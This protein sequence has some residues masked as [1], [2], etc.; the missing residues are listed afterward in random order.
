MRISRLRISNYRGI[1]ELDT[2]VG[3]GGLLVK[4]GNGLGKT[5][6]LNAVRAA[7]EARGIG[8]E[9]I[10]IGHDRAE[11]LVDMDHFAVKRVITRDRSTVKITDEDGAEVRSP[12]KWLN[13]LVGDGLDPI[14]FFEAKPKDRK[15]IL[16]QA[17]PLRID[18]DTLAKHLP[19]DFGYRA[20]CADRHAL[21]VLDEVRKNAYDQ[22]TLVNAELK[23]VDAE[24]ATIEPIPFDPAVKVT[25]AEAKQYSAELGTALDGLRMKTK[26]NEDVLSKMEGWKAK[27]EELRKEADAIRPSDEERQAALD[28]MTAAKA[29]VDEL[30]EALEKARAENVEAARK[31]QEIGHRSEKAAALEKQAADI[32]EAKLPY[33]IEEGALQR[34]ENQMEKAAKLVEGALRNDASLAVDA[35]LKELSNKSREL[36][37]SAGSLTTI[38]KTMSETLP[39]E[40]MKEQAGVPGLT[41]DGDRIFIDGVDLEGLSGRE[42]LLIAVEVA[43][44]V[45]SKIK[46]LTVDKM[47]CIDPDHVEAFVKACTK[48]GYQLLATRVDRGE[49]VLEHIEAS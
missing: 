29:K 7:L 11:I 26:V 15:A 24:I 46:I 8:P 10:R 33:E 2:S 44:R 12:Q 31:H 48:D 19:P 28:E 5:S 45:N 13:E 17:F 40:L 27:G 6:V 21:D 41:I 36:G 42:Q 37:K 4:G 25:G 35:Q 22:R 43:R 38:I 20:K 32:P 34:L 49:I 47:E 16:F 30:Y 23:K 3:D 39:A 14:T 1:E 18:A 9:A